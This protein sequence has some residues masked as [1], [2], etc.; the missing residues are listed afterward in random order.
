LL[1]CTVKER[2]HILLICVTSFVSRIILDF[3]TNGIFAFDR[4]IFLHCCRFPEVDAW[5]LC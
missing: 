4:G 1:R 5:E 2:F 3:V